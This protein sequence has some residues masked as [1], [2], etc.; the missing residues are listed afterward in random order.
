MDHTHSPTHFY[1]N[2]VTTTW[3]ET[4]AQLLVFSACWVFSCFRHPPNFDTD[5]RIFNLRTWSFLCV[6]I[7]TGVGHTDSESAQHFLLRKTHILFLC[8]RRDSF[9]HWILS[10]KLYQLS[11][12]VTPND[13]IFNRIVV[14]WHLISITHLLRV[15]IKN[16]DSTNLSS[17]FYVK[18][19]VIAPPPLLLHTYPLYI[20]LRIFAW[21]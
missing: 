17:D 4:P 20:T 1:I 15:W 12:P 19:S 7:H 10:P 14:L 2:T 21:S 6:R 3:C 16:L 11:H 9:V 18:H 8:S 5:Y 13:M